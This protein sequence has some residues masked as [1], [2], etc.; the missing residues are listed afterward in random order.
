MEKYQHRPLD[1]ES[2]EIRLLRIEKSTDDVAPLVI[3]LRHAQLDDG[4]QFNA[5][6]YVWGEGGPTYKC[7]IRDGISEG[8]L[9]I[10]QN[11]YGFLST[12]RRL[13]ADWTT[14]W[15]WIDQICIK[16]EDHTERCHQV[17]QMGNLYSTAQATIV[18]PGYV[19]PWGP[20]EPESPRL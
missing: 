5:L 2:C 3:T 17:N 10:R 7:T 11:L 6:S 9:H 13:E 8:Y 15:I 19:D 20:S 16:Q 12:A 18:W 1:T 4:E 14:E